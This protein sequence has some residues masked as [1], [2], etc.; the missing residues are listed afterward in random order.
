MQRAPPLGAEIPLTEADLGRSTAFPER[1]VH[2]CLDV[3]GIR[4]LPHE[5]EGEAGSR[6]DLEEF[7]GQV[8]GV[9][10]RRLHLDPIA[11]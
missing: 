7:A 2:L 5:R 11:L 10:F 6:L 3:I 4:V 9:A 8:E 1:Q